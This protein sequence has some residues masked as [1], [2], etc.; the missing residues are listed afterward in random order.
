VTA[1]LNGREPVPAAAAGH[2]D[3][4]SFLLLCNGWWEPLEF[5]LPGP[6]FGAAWW[7]VV[8]TARG[9]PDPAG[10][11]VQAGGTVGLTGRSLLLL[12]DRPDG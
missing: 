2:P 1:F 11:P 12:R 6:A 9:T 5:T 8:D 7:P 4:A 3:A 10:G